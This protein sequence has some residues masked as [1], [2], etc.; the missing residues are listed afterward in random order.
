MPLEYPRRPNRE[1]LRF[2]VISDCQFADT[3]E[4]Y[5]DRHLRLARHKLREAVDTFRAD[6]GLAFVLNLG[7]LIDRG[8]EHFDDVLPILDDLDCPVHHVLGNH[9]FDV[10]DAC[11]DQ[12]PARLGRER[13][14]GAFSAGT[15]PPWR[16][17]VMDGGQVSVFAR[18]A[19]SVEGRHAEALRQS[20]P[21]PPEPWNG[22]AGA[23]QL[24]WLRGELEGARTA[25]E[26]VVVC[27][28]YPI[29]PPGERHVLW[30][31]DDV[32]RI[33]LAFDDVVAAFLCGHRHEGGVERFG[34]I[35]HLNFVG[36]ADTRDNAFAIVELE[37]REVSVWGFGRQPSY[38]F[39]LGERID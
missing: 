27:C 3:D 19:D 30:D 12:V 6:A 29:V 11:K 17:L 21:G 23:D 25:G 38:D 13:R 5:L 16:F 20:L 1:A 14:F 15:S 24:E 37:P 2:G 9:D 7:D 10:E 8:W 4:I 28:H 34:R 22:A 39:L 32:R 33:L 36:M 18:P 31:A 35:A 26:K